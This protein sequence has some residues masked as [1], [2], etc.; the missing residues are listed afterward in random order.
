MVAEDEFLKRMGSGMSIMEGSIDA[1]DNDPGIGTQ[2][3]DMT[4]SHV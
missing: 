2:N 3:D 1:H 4:P